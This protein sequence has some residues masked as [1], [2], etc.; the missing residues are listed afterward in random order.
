MLLC[1]CR[2]N[3]KKEI[4]IRYGGFY[5]DIVRALFAGGEGE[6]AKFDCFML[7]EQVCNSVHHG[8]SLT[9]K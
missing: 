5:I 1:N 6:F 3:S 8:T 9:L 2:C 7:N 4:R